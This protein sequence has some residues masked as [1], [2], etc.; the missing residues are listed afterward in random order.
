VLAFAQLGLLVFV[1]SNLSRGVVQLKEVGAVAS[2][3]DGLYVTALGAF[4]SMIGGILTWT[5]GSSWTST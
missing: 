3:G 2:L 4:I 5:R 1:G